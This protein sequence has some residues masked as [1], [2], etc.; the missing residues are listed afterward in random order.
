MW[1]VWGDEEVIRPKLF[2]AQAQEVD[3]SVF[4]ARWRTPSGLTLSPGYWYFYSLQGSEIHV[5]SEGYDSLDEALDELE[6]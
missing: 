2:R 1:P 5:I 4:D 3:Y 6:A